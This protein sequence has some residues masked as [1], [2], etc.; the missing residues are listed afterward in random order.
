[1]EWLGRQHGRRGRKRGREGNLWVEVYQLDLVEVFR[2]GLRGVRWGKDKSRGGAHPRPRRP[3]DVSLCSV[4]SGA[5][6]AAHW[7][8]A[9][10]RRG[11]ALGVQIGIAKM[12][13][14]VLESL[15]SSADSGLWSSSVISQGH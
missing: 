13:P 3:M 4:R 12:H 6:K 2:A 8:C 11:K 1:M 14:G 9:G 7:I 15:G 10:T 5:A